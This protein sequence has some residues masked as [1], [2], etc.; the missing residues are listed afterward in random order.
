MSTLSNRTVLVTGGTGFIGSALVSALLEL[1]ARVLMLG[2]TAPALVPDGAEFVAADLG[3]ADAISALS[4]R[5]AGVVAVAH[6]G[7]FIP[8]SGGEDDAVEAARANCLGTAALL[9]A[10]PEPP[11]VFCLASSVDVYGPSSSGLVREEQ[12]PNPDSFYGASK[13]AA[14]GIA[15]LHAQKG[16]YACAVLRVTHVYGPGDRSSKLVP[17]VLGRIRGGRAPLIFGEGDDARDLLYVDDV[18]AAFV[19]VL[20]ARVSGVFNVSSG[21][22]T[23]VAELVHGLLDASRSELEPEHRPAGDTP[24]RRCAYSPEKLRKSVAWR[25]RVKLAEGLRKTCEG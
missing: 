14:E 17:L 23:S 18:V 15:Q 16:G 25:P 7:G 2:R 3:E 8:R 11:E 10:L 6:L 21:E 12:A 1:G 9:D 24:P 20:E 5:L 19:A 22:A 4:D 13:L